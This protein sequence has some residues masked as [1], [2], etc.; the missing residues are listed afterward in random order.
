M[1]IAIP[2]PGNI[3]GIQ[4]LKNQ[5][6]LIQLFLLLWHCSQLFDFQEV[7]FRRD[8][9]EDWPIREVAPSLLVVKAIVTMLHICQVGGGCLGGPLLS[10]QAH[11]TRGF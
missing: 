7:K 9:R 2:Q 6:V 1:A 4:H 10:M 5:S 3:L 8:M 11:N